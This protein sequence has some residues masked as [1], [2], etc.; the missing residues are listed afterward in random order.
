MYCRNIENDIFFSAQS[1]IKILY[2]GHYRWEEKNINE[3]KNKYGWVGKWMKKKEKGRKKNLE[4]K[5]T[6]NHQQSSVN[7]FKAYHKKHVVKKI[8]YKNKMLQ[9]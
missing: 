4:K 5:L 1:D 3:M 9:I 2:P 8:R 6:I 7:T